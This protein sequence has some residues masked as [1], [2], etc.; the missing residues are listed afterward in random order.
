VLGREAVALP[1]TP[2]VDDVGLVAQKHGADEIAHRDVA[3]ERPAEALDPLVRG[4]HFLDRA[5]LRDQWRADRVRHADRAAARPER[6]CTPTTV[7]RLPQI[8]EL[9]DTDIDGD[10]LRVLVRV[11][12][13]EHR[14]PE[15]PTRMTLS[16]PKRWRTNSTTSS[17]S[18]R[19]WAMVIDCGGMSGAYDRPRAALFPVYHQKM[20]FE[21]PS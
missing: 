5:R 18:R 19:N 15:C 16:L 14:A 17:R 12:R 1:Q 9:A 21:A 13:T 8:G 4:E 10:L 20:L 6:A 2:Q 11:D 3:V 7:A